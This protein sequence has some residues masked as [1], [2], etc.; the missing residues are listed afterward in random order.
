MAV[1]GI[2]IAFWITGLQSA[3]VEPSYPYVFLCGMIAIYAMILPGIS[4]AYI[5]LLLGMYL[6]VTGAIK[7][8]PK[9]DVSVENL[10]T[11][12]VFCAG[13]VVGLLSFSKLLRWL[14]ARYSSPT[15][16]LLGGFMIGSLRKIWPF[17]RDLTPEIHELK[18][19][20]FENV[21]PETLDGPV[22]LA[23]VIAVAAVALVFVLDFTARSGGNPR[24]SA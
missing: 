23:I 5:L 15:M 24:A 20:R 3:A 2:A 9:G 14:L 10:V 8:L 17:K 11:I 19:K 6:H 12:A 13:C 18:L 1:A 16:A 22:A 4:G 21:L 7:G